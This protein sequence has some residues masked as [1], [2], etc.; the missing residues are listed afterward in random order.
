[1]NVDAKKL[2]LIEKIL[3][4]KRED[5]LE[6]LQAI[7]EATEPELEPEQKTSLDERLADSREGED[8]EIVKARLRRKP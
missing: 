3:H 6:Q 8:W 1:M 4:T 5:V 7:L 2:V